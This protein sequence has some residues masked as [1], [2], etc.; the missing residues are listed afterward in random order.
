MRKTL[1]FAILLLPCLALAAACEGEEEGA[2]LGSDHPGWG[3][4]GCFGNGC[5]DRDATHH[6]DL[7]PYECVECH[8]DNGAPDGHGGATPCAD[9][10]GQPH[11]NDGFPDPES[12]QTCH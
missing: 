3:D 7:Q 8:G 11:G 4:P 5:H 12:C 2:A 6:S 10:H 1:L 9:C